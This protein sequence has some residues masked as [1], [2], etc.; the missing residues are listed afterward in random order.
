MLNATDIN[1]E[2]I[3]ATEK[4]IRPYI[5]RTPTIAVRA[6]DFGL[7]SDADLAC[8]LEFL[9]HG[10]S[11]KV[12]GAF[13]NLLTRRISDAGVVAAQ[14]RAELQVLAHGHALEALAA[15]RRLA[16]AEPDDLE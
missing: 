7:D 9:Q 14:V 11:F 4:V 16:D 12:R 10:D 13:S 2:Q 5:R 15:L 1:R 6:A 8:K 3:A